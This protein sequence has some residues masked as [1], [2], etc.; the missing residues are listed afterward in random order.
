MVIS[1]IKQTTNQIINQKNLLN[2]CKF[3]ILS[4]NS[5]GI[6]KNWSYWKKA[7]V[8]NEYEK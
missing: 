3:L 1:Q 2:F 5:H 4:N 6:K 8:I 7:R